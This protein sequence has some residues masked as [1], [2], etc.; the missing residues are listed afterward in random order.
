MP[1]R[2]RG[3]QRLL[4]A[5]GRVARQAFLDEIPGSGVVR[6]IYDQARAELERE[7][8][9]TIEALEARLEQNRRTIRFLLG[10]LDEKDARI[11]EL[12]A[13]NATLRSER[14]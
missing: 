5:T 1:D 9:A 3:W 2:S 10:A 12:E 11:A 4:R 6:S 14:L 13:E 8:L 7:H